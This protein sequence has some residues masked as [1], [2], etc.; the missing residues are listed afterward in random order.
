MVL[1]RL[2]EDSLTAASLHQ[3]VDFRILWLLTSDG[4]HPPPHH[5]PEQRIQN[6]NVYRVD[7][8]DW[9]T[10]ATSGV[11]ISLSTSAA[12]RLRTPAA[13]QP[14]CDVAAARVIEL[15]CLAAVCSALQPLAAGLQTNTPAA[16]PPLCNATR[17]TPACVELNPL[18][19]RSRSEIV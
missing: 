15:L 9:L 10:F 16:A 14:A 8:Y 19:I 4:V 7:V 3:L 1:D 6:L 11:S 13:A 17:Q 5:L 12:A 2:L 18:G